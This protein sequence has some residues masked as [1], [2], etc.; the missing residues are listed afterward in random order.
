MIDDAPTP[1]MKISMLVI[2][3]AV[4]VGGFSLLAGLDRPFPPISEEFGTVYPV[5]ELLFRDYFIPLQL[6]G[7][8][9]SQLLN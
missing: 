5:A 2:V 9:L 8:L 6:T 4:G 1:G 3:A 7:V